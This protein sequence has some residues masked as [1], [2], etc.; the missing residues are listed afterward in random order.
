MISE[1]ATYTAA[2]TVLD[3]AYIR[4]V[5]VIY[6]RHKLSTCKQ[7]PAQS[8]DAFVQELQRLAKPC[9]FTEVTADQNR[10]EH[11]RDAFINGIASAT[12]RQRLLENNELTLDQ[13]LEMAR[14]R[15]RYDAETIPKTGTKTK[16]KA[17]K[18]GF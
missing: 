12:I 8:I 14:L 3:A 10:N 9:N 13:A 5:S 7:E 15:R 18:P 4:P 17:K 1:C 16:R 11:I 2:F 6:N